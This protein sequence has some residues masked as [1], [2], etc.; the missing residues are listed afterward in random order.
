MSLAIPGQIVEVLP[1]R[2]HLATVNVS[3]VRR[4]INIMML[5]DEAVQPGDWVLI[6]VG[7]AMAKI[8]AQEAQASLA[9]LE[10]IG[11]AYRDELQ[12]FEDSRIE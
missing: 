9:L 5:A 7:F 2:P 3:G 8:N 10:E 1:E 12:A 4:S 6:H 11:Q